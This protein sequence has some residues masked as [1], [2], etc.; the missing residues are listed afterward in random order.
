[1]TIALRQ[2]WL[3]V[4]RSQQIERVRNAL[5]YRNSRLD[6]WR[7]NRHE[8]TIQR[9]C[10]R[11]I[12]ITGALTFKEIKEKKEKNGAVPDVQLIL[13]WEIIDE[14][15]SSKWKTHFVVKTTSVNKSLNASR[16]TTFSSR[17]ILQPQYDAQMFYLYIYI[18]VRYICN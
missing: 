14:M 10:D 3:R 16:M 15:F 2:S 5:R 1:M 8:L 13:R 11:N 12:S 7:N 9:K 18:I 17:A 4:Y 6:Q